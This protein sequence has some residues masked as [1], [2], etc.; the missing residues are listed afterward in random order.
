[1]RFL[2][3]IVSFSLSFCLYGSELE[4]VNTPEGLILDWKEP[5]KVLSR[6]KIELKFLLSNL[7]QKQFIME[8]WVRQFGKNDIP[9]V[10][11]LTKKLNEESRIRPLNPV[12]VRGQIPIIVKEFPPASVEDLDAKVLLPLSDGMY[13]IWAELRFDRNVRS[14]RITI[15]VKGGKIPTQDR[16]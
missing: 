7:T 6:G 12:A 2:I 15:E 10:L 5:P 1:M 8:Q 16:K 9:N 3:Y 11:V 14:E 4:A 13:Q